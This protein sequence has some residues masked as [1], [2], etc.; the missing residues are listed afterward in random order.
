MAN[1]N[2]NIH[3]SRKIKILWLIMSENPLWNAS[4]SEI[5]LFSITF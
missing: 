3:P 1:I 5:F 2:L 4:H